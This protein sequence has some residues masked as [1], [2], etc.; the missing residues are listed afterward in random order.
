MNRV[1]GIQMIYEPS[2][3][4]L[5]TK[6]GFSITL[7]DSPNR[8][9]TSIVPHPL[10]DEGEDAGGLGARLGGRLAGGN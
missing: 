10:V 8:G 3:H 9:G 7:I 6:Y 5:G 1:P 4:I 2:I